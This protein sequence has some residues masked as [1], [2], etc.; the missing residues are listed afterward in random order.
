MKRL[1]L[2]I[3]CAALATGCA[4]SKPTTASSPTRSATASPSVDESTAPMDSSDQ[5]NTDASGYT[6]PQQ[7]Y[8]VIYA[9]AGRTETHAT[10]EPGSW[11]FNCNPVPSSPHGMNCEFTEY[12]QDLSSSSDGV[13]IW[14][15]AT[16][17]EKLS[18]YHRFHDQDTV[19]IGDTWYLNFTSPDTCNAFIGRVFHLPAF[20]GL[21]CIGP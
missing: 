19:V 4:S 15:F 9:E 8:S 2:L 7:L 10:P 13:G 16:S 20:D 5:A 12:A 17:S 21:G 1:A 14:A 3:I 18:N 11:E 6:K